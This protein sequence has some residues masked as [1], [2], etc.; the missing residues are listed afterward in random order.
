MVSPEAYLE[1]ERAAEVRH[2]LVDGEIVAMWGGTW[3]H[4]LIAQNIGGELRAALR[5]KPCQ[6]LNSD[7]RIW[8]EAT[9]RYRGRGLLQ[10]L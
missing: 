2:E 7:L 8:I 1:L 9:K 6:V 4:S 5:S 10:G 3:E